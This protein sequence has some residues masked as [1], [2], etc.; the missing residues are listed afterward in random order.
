MERH[1]GISAV[2]AIRRVVTML[3]AVAKATIQRE[4]GP[5]RVLREAN[6]IV[7]AMA[8]SPVRRPPSAV[9]RHV[10]SLARGA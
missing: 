1:F 9:P 4:T 7:R 5:D 2:V 6:D 10:S 3:R 8:A